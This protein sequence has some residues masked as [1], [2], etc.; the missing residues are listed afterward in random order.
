MDRHYQIRSQINNKKAVPKGNLNDQILLDS[1]YI[2][3]RKQPMFQQP[4]APYT[5]LFTFNSLVP[6]ILPVT[7]GALEPIPQPY[8]QS[9]LLLLHL[10]DNQESRAPFYPNTVFL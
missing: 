1:L 5:G 10:I 8:L 3:Y 4:V 7:F 9:E 6:Q 2:T